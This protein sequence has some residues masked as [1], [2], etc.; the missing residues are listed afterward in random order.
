MTRQKRA[1]AVHDISCVGKCSLTVVLPVLSAAGVET[2]VLPTSVL[3]THTGGFGTPVFHDLTEALSP[4][5]DHWASLGLTFDA[6]YTGYLGSQAQIE[7][8]E[9]LFHRFGNGALKLVDPVMGDGGSL[10][11]GFSS[12][13]PQEMKKLCKTADVLVPNFTEAALLLEEPYREGPYTKDYV[14]GLLRRLARLCPGSIVLTGVYF[15]HQQLG[16]ATFD[17]ATGQISYA[18]S[19]RVPG[20]FHGTGD[21]FASALLSALLAEKSLQEA[22]AIAARFTAQSIRLSDKARESKYGVR[23]EAALPSLMSDLELL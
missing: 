16:A 19:P 8:M 17:C 18:L 9:A 22:A 1:L 15:D 4:F 5:T 14:D 11:S 6:L 21:L 13:F 20:H 3:S 2:C 23:F 12:D 10:Y 7:Q